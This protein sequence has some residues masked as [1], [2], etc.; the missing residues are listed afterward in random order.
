MHS[1]KPCRYMP[2]WYDGTAELPLV[3]YF[4][5]STACCPPERRLGDPVTAPFDDFAEQLGFFMVSYF[6][7]AMFMQLCHVHDSGVPV[8]QGRVDGVRDRLEHGRAEGLT[9][10]YPRGCFWTLSS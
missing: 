4:H 6:D 5:G 10:R 8:R 7:S 3:L 9:Q 1:R 2:S